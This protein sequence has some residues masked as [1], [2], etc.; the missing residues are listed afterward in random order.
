VGVSV[1]G[2]S[3]FNRNLFSLSWA[4]LVALALSPDSLRAQEVTGR[5]T[6]EGAPVG[7]VQVV[8][9]R[10]ASPLAGGLTGSDGRFRLTGL[11]PGDITLTFQS[12]GYATTERVVTVPASGS[13][14]LD[15][16]LTATPVDLNPIVVSASLSE[17]R[18]RD[19]PV[20][21]EV[22]S[23][24]LLERNASQSL[25]D[26]VG[27]INGL[28]EQVDCGVCYTNSIRING[29][30]GPYTAVLIDGM[31]IM[32]ALASVYGLNGIDP[33]MVEQIEILKGPQSTLYGTEAMGGVINVITRDAR[34][35]PRYGVDVNT[36]DL[37]QINTQVMWA[38]TRGN[39]S[40]LLSAN[41]QHNDRFVDRN[42]DTFSDLT[43]DTRATFFG[44]TQVYRNGVE[45]FGIT[46][47]LYWEDRFGG[48]DEWTERD[49]G[50]STVYGESIETRRA[51]L[52]ARGR[53]PFPDVRAQLSYTY[54]DQDS[55][56]GDTFYGARQH[57]AFG[58]LVWDPA[59]RGNFD[60]M[61]G[62]SLRWDDYD[63]ETPATPQSD[64]RVIPGVF[65]EAT[66]IPAERVALLAGARVDHQDRHGTIVAPRATLKVEP[67][68]N[69]TL[70]GSFGTG[71]RIVNLFTEDHAAL[72]GARQVVIAEGLEP[73]ESRSFSANLNQIFELG[74]NNMMIDV[75][76]F[77]TEFT[78]QIIPDYDTNPNQIIYANLNG[79]SVSRGFSVSMNQNFGDIPFLYN[80][81]FTLQDVYEESTAGDREAI[82]FAADYTGTWGAQYTFERVLGG[83]NV[84][85]TGQLVGPMRLPEFTEP[86]PRP[87]RS[88]AFTQHDIQFS[89]EVNEGR[90]FYLGVE[91]LN[92]FRQP[93]PVIDPGNPFG[94]NFDTAYAYGPVVGRRFFAGVRLT[95]GR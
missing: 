32:G 59:R 38:P 79:T 8:A 77:H 27:R 51:E 78:N 4:A 74:V 39:V 52:M 28:Y 95:Q 21:V 75:D 55:W 58:Q 9:G 66:W 15:V 12:M 5:V 19:T 82:P 46:G 54:H 47:K 94:P 86:E 40:S 23:P 3:F 48:L 76:V 18:V 2:S 60:V 42:N 91:N 20:K 71:F 72:T 30:E 17:Q 7:S 13:V 33:R 49:L 64:T 35:A 90:E 25:I 85:Y 45:Q 36:S 68:R 83:L 16:A 29:M 41:V 87:T 24:R 65:G 26:A 63:D 81:G 88:Q 31:P 70:R 57:I 80:L 53:L 22:I 43:L 69:G 10:L 73:E 84:A 92:D 34:F 67:W 6:A 61:A 56:Y 93:S 50:S 37:G 89:V 11:E 62:T 14:H 44:K 1:V